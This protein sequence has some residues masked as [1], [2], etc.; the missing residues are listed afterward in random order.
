MNEILDRVESAGERG[1]DDDDEK[2]RSDMDMVAHVLNVLDARNVA[3]ALG[4]KKSPPPAMVVDLTSISEEEEEDDEFAEDALFVTKKE[5]KRPASYS[6][7]DR[8]LG[9]V[10]RD[11][12]I[13]IWCNIVGIMNAEADE[14]S[15]GLKSIAKYQDVYSKVG[16]AALWSALLND[17]SFGIFSLSEKGRKKAEEL[18]RRKRPEM[19]VCMP[20]IPS[21]VLKYLTSAG[22]K[23]T[24]NPFKDFF[25]GYSNGSY[26]G[27]PMVAPTTMAGRLYCTRTR[28]YNDGENG[29]GKRTY[30]VRREHSLELT[31]GD[32][33]VTM[34]HDHCFNEENSTYDLG[35]FRWR[36]RPNLAVINSEKQP[37]MTVALV[38]NPDVRVHF[39]KKDGLA[40][41]VKGPAVEIFNGVGKVSFYCMNGVLSRASGPA[42]VG[43]SKIEYYFAGK[44]ENYEHPNEPA[45]VSANGNKVYYQNGE[46]HRHWTFGPAVINEK[47][48]SKIKE[49]YRYHGQLH[50]PMKDG[51]AL[52]FRNG[53]YQYW[54]YGRLSNA[55]G[56]A[57]SE[58]NGLKI[59]Y[60]IDG[61]TCTKEEFPE[62]AK[63]YL[64]RKARMNASLKEKKEKRRALDEMR[65]ERA[66]K[67]SVVVGG[68]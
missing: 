53:D 32:F 3:D 51:P 67:T 14:D 5:K 59:V 35:L 1:S 54:E 26:Y 21:R 55:Y 15:E 9:E 39:Y 25:V 58:N 33:R 61:E 46:K 29:D 66:E 8:P 4:E 60:A 57:A 24:P 22:N 10:V 34:W 44:R 6:L 17:K 19:R 45:I 41:R 47:G 49:E 68:Q 30:K 65:A 18:F 62:K 20:N 36:H 43:L 13:E 23:K 42:I 16:G 50:R 27:A 40:H 37:A 52:T 11:V 56:I 31:E 12:P 28:V 38:S 7:T 63:A 2:I 48:N 64:E